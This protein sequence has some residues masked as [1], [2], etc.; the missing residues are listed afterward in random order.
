MTAPSRTCVGA[1]DA[2]ADTDHTIAELDFAPHTGDTVTAPAAAVAVNEWTQWIPNSERTDTDM[3][4]LGRVTDGH[5]AMATGAGT[6]TPRLQH[7]SDASCRRCVDARTA[8]DVVAAPFGDGMDVTHDHRTLIADAD[9]IPR[10]CGDGDVHVHVHIT[11]ASVCAVHRVPD[12]LAL[13]PRVGVKCSIGANTFVP[14]F[15]DT[16]HCH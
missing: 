2:D 5:H 4:P 10:A 1:A 16:R 6:T 12:R 13:Q 3:G 7:A 15:P 9:R 8:C 11:I 14:L